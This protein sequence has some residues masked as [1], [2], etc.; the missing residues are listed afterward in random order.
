[1]AKMQ[2]LNFFGKKRCGKTSEIV[3]GILLYL[4]LLTKRCCSLIFLKGSS[5][6][7]TLLLAHTR[8]KGGV[9]GERVFS[10]FAEEVG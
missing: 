3:N 1:M 5:R 2:H 4:F 6:N 8:Q 10:G 9:A 7:V